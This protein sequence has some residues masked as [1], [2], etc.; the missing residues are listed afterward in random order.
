[1][2]LVAVAVQIVDGAFELAQTLRLA[3]VDGRRRQPF[4]LVAVVLEPGADDRQTVL[5]D[6]GR[7]FKNAI[8]ERGD[9]LRG[10]ARFVEQQA[11]R[12]FLPRRQC[13]KPAVARRFSVA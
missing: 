3:R 2:H 11:Q 8:V 7:A 13:R 10:K 4:E 5:A 9:F 12:V 1:M 6:P